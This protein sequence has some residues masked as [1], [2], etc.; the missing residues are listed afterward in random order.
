MAVAVS[1]I[2]KTEAEVL[3]ADV[4]GRRVSKDAAIAGSEGTGGVHQKRSRR[5][6]LIGG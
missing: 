5:K 1:R 6:I 3:S 2:S 4:E